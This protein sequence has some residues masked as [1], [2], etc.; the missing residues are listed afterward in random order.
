[1]DL[2]ADFVNAGFFL[3][4]GTVEPRKR[5][6]Q[7]LR[8]FKVY[9]EQ[10]ATDKKLVIV[11]R[12]GWE[13]PAVIEALSVA[14]R[15]GWLVWLQGATDH[16]LHWLYE[17]CKCLISTSA[18]EGFN[19]PVF[20]ALSCRKAVL[21][22]KGTAPTYE[23]VEVCTFDGDDP[24]QIADGIKTATSFQSSVTLPDRYSAQSVAEHLLNT[25]KAFY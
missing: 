9:R 21:V 19:M 5:Y 24:A 8:G 13:E 7:L 4:V 17:Q 18:Y 15:E 3:A 11:G 20:E 14:A 1:V 10:S 16:E 2:P 25:V 23:K 6:L 22:R 12:L